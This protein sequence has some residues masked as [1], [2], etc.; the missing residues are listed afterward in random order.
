LEWLIEISNEFNDVGIRAIFSTDERKKKISHVMRTH[1]YEQLFEQYS[2]WYFNGKKIVPKDLNFSSKIFLKN[3]VYGDGTLV[4]NSTL[5]LCTDDF[6]VFAAESPH[7]RRKFGRKASERS[8]RV[9][10]QTSL[11]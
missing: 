1:V 5:R 10:D 2:K 7:F 6:T 8:E 3:W 4:N 11:G 9:C